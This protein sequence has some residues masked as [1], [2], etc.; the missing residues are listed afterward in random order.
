MQRT[1][2]PWL[3]IAAIWLLLSACNLATS[4]APP[5][6]TLAPRPT[7]TPPPTLGFSGAAGGAGDVVPE[8]ITTP[9]VDSDLQVL[10]LI[11]Q[12]E[13][14]RLMAH[15]DTLQN[16]YTRH[17]NSITSS[18]TQGI[19]AA[20]KYIQDQF[21][22]IRAVS[23]GRLYV[24]VQ[25]FP[26]EWGGVKSTQQNII[27]VVQG[28]EPGAGTIVVGA[29]YDSIV[30]PN[31]NDGISFAPGANDNATGVAAIIEMARIMSQRPHRSS[32]MFVAFSAEE[33]GRKGSIAFVQYLKTQ[34]IDVTQMINIDTIGNQE[35]FNG[36][37]NAREM[38]VFSQGPNDA[39]SDRHLARTAEFI[40]FTHGLEMKL[41]VEDKI[42]RENRFG[43]HFSFTEAGYPAIRFISAYEEKHNGDPTDT[44]EYV[45][46][47]YLRRSTQAIL[48]VISS[49][50]DAPRP[51]KNIALRPVEGNVRRL[52]WEEVPDAAGYIVALRVAGS[53]RYDQQI[54]INSSFVDWD[55]FTYY[56]GI[57][58]AAKGKDGIVGPLS[59]EF[60][61]P[62]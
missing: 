5:P 24:Y 14:D 25:D 27:A 61:V 10:N 55:G 45:E 38:R 47:A 62:K 30:A 9:I 32:I 13:S 59:R 31:F 39:S 21:E 41:I 29:H 6:P 34:G 35:D 52:I 20:R 53:L 58:I 22:A 57:A 17:V 51:P 50:A 48:V 36:A 60:K 46:P 8:N 26:L 37:V 15:V 19:G 40:S 56:E 42:D 16:F 33:V 43:D 18:A 3:F 1:L 44:I 11:N 54:E 2:R 23:N 49:L 4:S 7:A 28:S 12:V